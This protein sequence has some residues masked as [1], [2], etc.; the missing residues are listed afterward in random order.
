MRVRKDL[1]DMGKDRKGWW[2]VCDMK[3][4]RRDI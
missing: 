2:G 3:A 4:E 1:E